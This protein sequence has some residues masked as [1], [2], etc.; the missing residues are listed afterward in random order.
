MSKII[1][2]KEQ[3]EEM[4]ENKNIAKCS[5]RS[6]TYSNDFKMKAMR[7]YHEEGMSSGEIFR[8]A[9]FNLDI[10]GKRKPK[11]CLKFWNKIYREKG[12]AGLSIE[13]RGRGGGRPKTK[14]LTD[15]DK[16]KRLETEVAYLKAEND[17]LA[18]L[19]ASKKR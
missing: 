15:A 6:I 3:I 16:I 4:S 12:M 10:I 19:R 8:Q 2:T 11:D 7:Q 17:F 13:T 9:G 5:E 1:F 18:K 14:D